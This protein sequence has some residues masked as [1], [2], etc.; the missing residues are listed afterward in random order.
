MFLRN[1][2]ALIQSVERVIA[3]HRSNAPIRI[4]VAF[5]G[6]GA[7][8]LLS[9]TGSRVQIVCNLMSGGT[10]PSVIRCLR[11]K[12][13]IEVLQ[14]NTLHAKVVIGDSGAIISSANF[15]T[16]GLGIEGAPS[17]NEAGYF[18]ESTHPAYQE[19]ESWF[20][21]I[22][23]KSSVIKPED[24]VKADLRWAARQAR[25]REDGE[26]AMPPKVQNYERQSKIE[27]SSSAADDGLDE[28]QTVHFEG[29]IKPFQRDLR[30]AAAFVALNGQ[31]GGAMP[32]SAFIFL[33]S[34][35]KTRRAFDNHKDKFEIKSH[36][37]QCKKEFIGYF[38]GEDG[39]LSSSID[40]KRTQGADISLIQ[41]TAEWMLGKG[42]RPTG[43]EGTRQAARF[44][45]R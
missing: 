7:E 33:F 44:L 30:S 20:A 37:L 21:D 17:W 13:N 26:S 12:P 23:S 25:D 15:S 27:P 14:L 32:A 11:L 3:N 40:Q 4:A 9:N 28:I 18:I 45:I 22:Q 1:S 10:N 2:D 38:V 16:N 34:G 24:I 41:A 5:W 35:G 43:L 19:I 29:R 36:T 6:A 39:S 42:P 31:N 8:K